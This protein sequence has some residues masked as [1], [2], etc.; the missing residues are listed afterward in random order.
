MP[1]TLHSENY[2]ILYQD[3]HQKRA[4]AMAPA[5]SQLVSL[6]A[7]A[8]EG[9]DTLVFWGHGTPA[10]LC[11]MHP[12]D[13]AD[14]VKRWRAV[15]KKIDTIEI[16]TCNSRHAPTGSDPFVKQLRSQLGFMLRGLTIKSMP[17]RMGPGGLHGDSI[18]FADFASKTWCYMT[19][20]SEISLGGLRKLYK[21]LCEDEFGDDAIET[22]LYLTT[23][24]PRRALGGPVVNPF[25]KWSREIK[26]I[27]DSAQMLAW[28][29]VDG[30]PFM[31]TLLAALKDD[32]YRREFIASR[33]YSMNY[34]TFDSL[35]DQL[36]KVT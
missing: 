6:P 33:K 16:L 32:G 22:A 10:S 2:V 1:R 20:H 5:K 23:P 30:H 35:W 34:G 24:P 13:V 27:H 12:K 17:V 4:H 15:N 28:M 25:P 8:V 9:M 19:T 3:D 36:V 21:R 31:K 18:L 7:K 14:V 11:G 26:D 29:S